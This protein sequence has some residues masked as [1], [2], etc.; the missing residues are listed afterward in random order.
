MSY[1]TTIVFAS[2]FVHFIVEEFAV[3]Q[4]FATIEITGF[5]SFADEVMI[6]AKYL[7]SS[8]NKMH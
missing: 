1:S 8:N 2:S 7:N 4:I 6:L 5:V 3:I